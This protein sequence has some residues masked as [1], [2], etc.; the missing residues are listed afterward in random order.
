MKPTL[1]LAQPPKSIC[2][3]RLSA[4]GDCTHVVPVVRTLQ[5]HWPET[6]I[7]WIVGKNEASLVGDLPGVEFLT[8]DKK[9]KLGTLIDLY[10]ALEGRT[11]DVLLNMQVAARATIANFC[12]N[13]SIKLGYDK[14]RARDGQWIFTTHKIPS[15]P[16]QHVL[17]SFFEF[18]KT[19]GVEE[20]EL[21]WN[22]PIPAEAKDFIAKMVPDGKRIL[23]INPSASHPIRNWIPSR[24]AELADQ[25]NQKHQLQI[26]LSGG[27][28]S[29]EKNLATVIVDHCKSDIINLVG[30]TNLKQL[31]ALL[32][33]ATVMV[34]PDTGP[35]HMATAV[36]TPVIG[37]YA[38]SNPLRSGPYLSLDHTVNHY[39]MMI[40]EAFGLETGRVRWGTR[41]K[42]ERAMESITVEHVMDKLDP[43]LAG[44]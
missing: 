20:R 4:I 15:K 39:P 37:L 21:T 14:A 24:Y 10:R 6:Q 8:F 17:E 41:V 22:L 42:T 27:P 30:K 36:G 33:K 16:D 2:I 13:A 7:T 1:P 32:D 38:T 3:L 9:R 18:A 12:I 29:A 44:T 40:R 34:A 25:A 28:S 35:A 26:V 11:F 23:V 19:V 5:K 31:L 43:L